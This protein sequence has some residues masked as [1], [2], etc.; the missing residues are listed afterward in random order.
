MVKIYDMQKKREKKQSLHA[1]VD[2]LL[3]FLGLFV[4]C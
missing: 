4:F 1:Q 3:L 2:H